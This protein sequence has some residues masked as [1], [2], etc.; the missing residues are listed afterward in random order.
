MKEKTDV[1]SKQGKEDHMPAVTNGF[2]FN[3]ISQIIL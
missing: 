3:N 1:I 2:I